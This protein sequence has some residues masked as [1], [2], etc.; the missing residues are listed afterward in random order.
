[1]NESILTSLISALDIAVIEQST[2][3]SFEVLGTPPN[4]FKN[5][6]P[7]MTVDK[8]KFTIE[9][10]LSFLSSFVIDAAEFW[11]M[12][13]S[14]QILWSGPWEEI[15][16]SG[17]DA[18]L[19]AGATCLEEKNILIIKSLGHGDMADQETLQ[20]VKEGL[21]AFEDLSM[22]NKEMEKYEAHLEQEVNKRTLQVKKT[23]EGV[24]H[25][26]ATI[27][28]MRDPYT[29]GH[30][31]RVA[32]L[33]CA[34]AKE[35][36]R[37]AEEIEG[38]NIA[39]ALHDIGK[40]H[41]PA[42]ILSK[43]GRLTELEIRMI[44][45]HCQAGYDI[46]NNIEFPWPIA[47]IILQHHENMDGSGY[48]CGL[49]GEDILLRARILR[50]ADVVEAMASNRPYRPALGMGQALE[51]IAKNKGKLYDT[52]VVNACY[53]LFYEKGFKLV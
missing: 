26:I 30:Q 49:S 47:Q 40:M 22:T 4:W 21:L 33:S 35:M 36:L 18:V 25:A 9:N 5:L 20:K 31:R 28:E 48:P 1:M 29:A 24:T 44:R 32:E 15:L 27:T 10:D 8:K 53:N 43:P 50:V 38:L 51:E 3:G 17:E 6:F 46:L 13:Q 14:G 52:D 19:E 16:E 39:G 42:E 12:K 41:V 11:K 37:P 45:T 7:Q 23:L 2:N 34:I